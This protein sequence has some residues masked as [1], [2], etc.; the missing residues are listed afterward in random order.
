MRVGPWLS[1]QKQVIHALDLISICEKA[2]TR[3]PR[4][5]PS[6]DRSVTFLDSERFSPLDPL[7]SPIVAL[8]FISFRR[9]SNLHESF[10][11]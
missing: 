4:L 6:A 5:C 3:V 10:L 2:G 1:A 7:D 8:A 11:G 9:Y